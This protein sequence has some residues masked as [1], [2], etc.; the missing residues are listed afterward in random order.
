M[1]IHFSQHALLQ[2]Q[3]RNLAHADIIRTVQ[4]PFQKRQQSKKRYQAIRV[5]L[6]EQKRYLLVVIYDQK[7]SSREIVTAFYSSKLHK[8]L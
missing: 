8:Y 3:E 2:I 7:T 6:R 1:K 5:V 4:R